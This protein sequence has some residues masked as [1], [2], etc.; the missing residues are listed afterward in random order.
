MAA[1]KTTFFEIAR[2][3]IFDLL[4]FAGLAKKNETGG[5]VVIDTEK[6][7][8]FLRHL[9]PH[10]FGIGLNDEAI[11]NN[12]LAKLEDRR[13]VKI[14]RFLALQTKYDQ[15]R[16][17]LAVAILPDE[18]D[19]IQVLN[20]YSELIDTREM[21]LVAKSTGMISGTK[22]PLSTQGMLRA[23]AQILVIYT[24]ILAPIFTAVNNAA[25]VK[26]NE[27]NQTKF[28]RLANRLFR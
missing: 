15:K 11:M 19:R 27:L 6:A 5:K 20:M 24:G 8:E 17:G 7:Q 21:V 26:A 10:I 1:D 2:E 14:S 22:G 4:I 12:T 28:G 3:L 23:R 9:A 18:K 13:Q 16:F 25:L